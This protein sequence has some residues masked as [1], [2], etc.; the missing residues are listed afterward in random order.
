MRGAKFV[1]VIATLP[2]LRLYN[3]SVRF[4]EQFYGFLALRIVGKCTSRHLFRNG[5]LAR[6]ERSFKYFHRRAVEKIGLF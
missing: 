6:N 2:I 1:P 3:V 5:G 4:Y